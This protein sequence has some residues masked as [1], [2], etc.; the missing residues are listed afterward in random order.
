MLRRNDGSVRTKSDQQHAGADQ[1]ER[2]A[3]AAAGAWNAWASDGIA[4]VAAASTVSIDTL[5]AREELKLC[6][7]FLSPPTMNATPSTSTLFARIEPTSAA[8]T[9]LTSPSCKA[10]SAMKSSG[11][12]PSAGLDDAR[13]ARAEPRAQLLGRGADEAGERGERDGGDDERRDV[14]QPREMADP[15]QRRPRVP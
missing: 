11:R 15:G 13:A 14:V 4:I 9:T 12:L 10:K 2:L 8:W 5:R 7:P 3:C 1:R 6:V